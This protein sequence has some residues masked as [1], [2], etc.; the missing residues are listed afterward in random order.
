MHPVFLP[1]YP[2]V[3]MI[4]FFY[5]RERKREKERKRDREKERERE[6]EREGYPISA[7]TCHSVQQARNKLVMSTQPQHATLLTGRTLTF[8]LAQ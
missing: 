3:L 7:A 6:R 1:N 5:E 2:D 4:D 8:S